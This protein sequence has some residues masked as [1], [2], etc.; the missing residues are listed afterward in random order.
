[1]MRD[2]DKEFG[3]RW[4]Y[5]DRFIRIAMVEDFTVHFIKN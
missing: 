5:T 3:V 2:A 1:M 4:E